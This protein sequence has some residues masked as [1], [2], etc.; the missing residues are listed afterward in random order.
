[1]GIDGLVLR[2][3]ILK[4][5]ADI[6]H[7]G[8]DEHVEDEE[9]G[10][11]FNITLADDDQEVTV[12][13]E[14]TKPSQVYKFEVLAIEESGNQTIAESFFCTE[15]LTTEQCQEMALEL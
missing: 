8:D 9:A 1:M 4:D 6:L 10:K 7:E 3:V 15:P 5:P 14:F 11:E 13:N 2:P 12:P